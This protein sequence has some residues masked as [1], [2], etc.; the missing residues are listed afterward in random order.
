MCWTP[1]QCAPGV[2]I[3]GRCALEGRT[4]AIFEATE[5]GVPAVRRLLFAPVDLAYLAP[6]EPPQGGSIPAVVTLGRES[7]A[8]LLAKFD[9]P[10][11]E[12]ATIVEAYLLLP[13]A[14]GV[15]V[16]PAGS[17]PLYLHALRIVDPWDSR[18]VRW[19]MQPRTV[20]VHAPATKVTAAGR[21]LV[22]LDVRD[23]VARWPR[24]EKDDDGI[25]VVATTGSVGSRGPGVAFG[26]ARFF[27]EVYVKE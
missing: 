3:A 5:A 21:P 15:D 14:E 13:V 12:G 18:S 9:V 2:C 25:A 23:I 8:R 4:P 27:L 24:R 22:R 26:M 17:S 11:S 20:E 16:D 10:L 1:G 7:D 19:S 6:G